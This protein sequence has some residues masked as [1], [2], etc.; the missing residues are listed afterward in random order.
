M[1]SVR[2]P[3]LLSVLSVCDVGALWPDGWNGRIKIKRGMQVGLGP[4]H[5][6]LGGNP[7]PPHGKEHSNPPHS[8][9]TG[10]GFVCVR[11]I[12]GPCLLSPNGCMDQDATS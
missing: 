1:L 7:A 4:G 10:A 12:R 8:K 2:C 3:V 5:I 11:I 6:V 9:F